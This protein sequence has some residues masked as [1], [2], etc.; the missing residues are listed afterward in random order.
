MQHIL[1]Y[2]EFLNEG[3]DCYFINPK[4]IN[5]NIHFRGNVFWEFL[6]DQGLDIATSDDKYPN[7]NAFGTH[8]LIITNPKNIN[9]AYNKLKNVTI[10]QDDADVYYRGDLKSM[11]EDYKEFLKFFENGI[12]KKWYYTSSW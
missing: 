4:N 8:G 5:K 6:S 3:L 2:E 10:D 12:K 7:S 1:E 11:K 9:D